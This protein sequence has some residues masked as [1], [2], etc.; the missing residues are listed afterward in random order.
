MKNRHLLKYIVFFFVCVLASECTGIN[1]GSPVEKSI[2]H[3]EK[4]VDYSAVN[5]T[6]SLM[7]AELSYGQL[8]NLQLTLK[9]KGSSTVNVAKL[10]EFATYNIIYAN[11]SGIFYEYQPSMDLLG[12]DS[13]VELNPN[14][15]LS[16]NI[17][18]GLWGTFSKGNHSLSAKYFVTGPNVFTRP[19]WNG[20][21][22]SNNITLI[23]E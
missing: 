10:E 19:H 20:L 15:S 1:D 5:L 4:T 6:L 8:S 21:L 18:T 16:I 17:S 11:G 23:V 2:N 22:R 14:D 9:N 3:S 13:L 12:D 7:P